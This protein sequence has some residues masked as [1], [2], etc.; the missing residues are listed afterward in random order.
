VNRNH[1]TLEAMQEIHIGTEGFGFAVFI[2]ISNSAGHI[3]RFKAAQL[4]EGRPPASCQSAA[5]ARPGGQ[6]QV[7]DRSDDFLTGEFH[8]YGKIISNRLRIGSS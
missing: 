2:S 3:P 5:E 6:T 1:P 7:S 8:G 4:C